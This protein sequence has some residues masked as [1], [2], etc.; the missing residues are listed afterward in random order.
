M[1]GNI[2]YT[3]EPLYHYVKHADSLTNHPETG[4]R[5]KLRR[6]VWDQLQNM[7]ADAMGAYARFV[8]GQSEH[9]ELCDE[10]RRISRRHVGPDT[11]AALKEQASRLRDHITSTLH[12]RQ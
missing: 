6:Q 10:L 12:N 9:L 11:E 5:S 3:D 4:M 8:N 1:I 7:Y 2:A